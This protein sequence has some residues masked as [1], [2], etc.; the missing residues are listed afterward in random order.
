MKMAKSVFAS[1]TL[2]ILAASIPLTFFGALYLN[3]R[4]GE[5]EG[6]WWLLWLFSIPIQVFGTLLLTT[7]SRPA[8]IRWVQRVVTA[9]SATAFATWLVV[10][11][12]G[13]VGTR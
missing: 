10:R 3:L 5:A 6:F 8:V 2:R 1:R 13:I 4:Y 7:Y 12:L 9:M 11:L